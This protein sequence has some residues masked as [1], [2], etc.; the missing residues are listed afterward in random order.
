M[1][2]EILSEKDWVKLNLLVNP[3]NSSS[4]PPVPPETL[5]IEDPVVNPLGWDLTDPVIIIFWKTISL[6]KLTT[7][8]SPSSGVLAI[9]VL[10]L[11]WG[12]LTLFLSNKCCLTTIPVET[13]VLEGTY[14]LIV[15]NKELSIYFINL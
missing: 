14:S 8:G 3:L 2:L 11:G 12:G 9:V 4:I 6:L 7:S 10:I 5:S 1:I 13:D 15:L